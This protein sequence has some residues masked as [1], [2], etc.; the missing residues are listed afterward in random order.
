M[1][2]KSFIIGFLCLVMAFSS[3]LLFACSVN[4]AGNATYAIYDELYT[5]IA[6]DNLSISSDCTLNN[7]CKKSSDGTPQAD[8]SAL[9]SLVQ[10]GLKYIKKYYPLVKNLS[11]VKFDTVR[12]SGNKLAQAYKDLNAQYKVLINMGEDA[13]YL[14]YNAYFY[15][16]RDNVLDFIDQVYDSANKLSNFLIKDA[17]VIKNLGK[18]AQTN[19]DVKLYTDSEQLKVFTDFKKLFAD[20]CK[21]RELSNDIYQGYFMVFK[22][23]DKLF[24]DKD[25]KSIAYSEVED[26]RNFFN[27]LDG[28]RAKYE[29]TLQNFSAYD[30]ENY[31]SV[32]KYAEDLPYAQV[33]FDSLADYCEYLV[34]VY[35]F[36]NNN[37]FA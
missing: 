11:D 1:K 9:N 14:I 12:T 21:G 25:I 33:Y 17:K 15:S 35:E 32:A 16:Y 7:F 37:I 24:V 28:E 20:N 6:E 36:L 13:N 34:Y 18:E 23:Y 19:E 29:R 2:K 4:T 31:E 27:G 26:I 3:F 30:F 5:K 22:A 8:T 10:V